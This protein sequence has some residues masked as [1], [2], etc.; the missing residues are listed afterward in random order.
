ME[1][2]VVML[3]ERLGALKAACSSGD[4][5]P[6]ESRPGLRRSS[7]PKVNPDYRLETLDNEQLLYDPEQTRVLA[8]NETA[9][10]IW[11]LCDGQRTV[12]EIAA[13]LAD[14]FPEAAD[15]MLGMWRPLWRSSRSTAR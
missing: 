2:V 4:T 12:D 3:A 8:C 1:R 15:T 5:I 9:S 11:R 14:A 6:M 13:L 7:R 10:L